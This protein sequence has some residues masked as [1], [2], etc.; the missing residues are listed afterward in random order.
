MR[1][2]WNNRA[3]A[4]FMGLFILILSTCFWAFGSF[5][6][7]SIVVGNSL[8]RC[9][10]KRENPPRLK[11]TI[12]HC[13]LFVHFHWEVYNK[14]WFCWNWCFPLY[15]RHRHE[16]SCQILNSARINTCPKISNYSFNVLENVLAP[17]IVS[18]C[19]YHPLPCLIL[20]DKAAVWFL[21]IK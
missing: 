9:A 7:F 13:V 16:S 2:P 17:S 14:L 20:G 6:F 3:A 19:A 11:L 1:I 4:I 15:L 18:E 10:P 21:C 8:S 12:K 5:A